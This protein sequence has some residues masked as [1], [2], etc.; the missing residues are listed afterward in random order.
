MPLWSCTRSL[1]SGRAARGSS[2]RKR[3][4]GLDRQ[5]ALEAFAGNLDGTKFTAE[6][7][8]FI[9]LIVNE[10]TANGVLEP[11]RP[12]ES[13][14]TDHTPTGPESVFAEADVDNIVEILD[15]VKANALPTDGAA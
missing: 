6:Q 8:R 5:A 14:Y 2:P 7:I 10:L 12:Y 4:V 13:P 9:N 1:A 3:L 15:T 11:A